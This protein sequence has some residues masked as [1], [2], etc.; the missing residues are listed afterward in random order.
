V[1]SHVIAQEAGCRFI[2]PE[3]R[4]Q[5]QSFRYVIFGERILKV[6]TRFLRVHRFSLVSYGSTNF[7]LSHLLSGAGTIGSFASEV[8][9]NSSHPTAG[10]KNKEVL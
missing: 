1:I 3:A 5:F 6:S 9:S 7:P 2:A 4:I 8:P 10:I